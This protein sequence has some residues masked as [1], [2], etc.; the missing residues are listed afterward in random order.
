MTSM[1][2]AEEMKEIIEQTEGRPEVV[3]SR[4]CRNGKKETYIRIRKRMDSYAVPVQ[5][6][7]YME[8]YLN[9]EDLTRL[10]RE[11]TA[12]Y[13]LMGNMSQ[14]MAEEILDFER[15]KDRI[16]LKLISGDDEQLEYRPHKMLY[17]DLAAVYYIFLGKEEFKLTRCNIENILYGM[18]CVDIDMLH[19][20]A[21]RNTQRLLPGDVLTI[22]SIFPP[23]LK[24]DW[25]NN[26][27][28][29]EHYKISKED[30]CMY[31]CT[32]DIKAYGAAVMLYDGLLE[33]FAETIGSDFYIL[34]SSRHEV[35]FV[36]FYGECAAEELQ[37][38]VRYVN[39]EIV[40]KEDYLSDSVYFYS[41]AEGIKKYC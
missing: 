41:Q 21:M 20:I 37:E 9:G 25:G 11:I 27:L 10:S 34:P 16:C 40:H 28:M 31:I 8:R 39:G 24:T 15:I 7:G 26:F 29:K 30:S 14:K 32:N 2:F 22:E 33:D 13:M 5:V 17:Y 3:I 19:S 35:I 23:E 36:P 18:Y 38:I 12:L 6:D 1:E 4:E